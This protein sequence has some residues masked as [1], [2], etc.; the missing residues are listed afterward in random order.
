MSQQLARLQSERL[1]HARRDGQQV[2]YTLPSEQVRGLILALHVTFCRKAKSRAKVGVLP[3]P[4][5]NVIELRRAAQNRWLAG[6]RDLKPSSNRAV[7]VTAE[8]HRS[9]GLDRRAGRDQRRIRARVNADQ[10][11]H[12]GQGCRETDDLQMRCAIGGMK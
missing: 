7:G 5:R 4:A 6:D 3:R 2:F 1:M 12:D 9:S 11:D 8:D 10:N